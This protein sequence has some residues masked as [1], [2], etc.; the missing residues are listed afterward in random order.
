VL[1]A[2][3]AGLKIEMLDEKLTIR[4]VHGGNMTYD[5]ARAR[6]A[7]F[8]AFKRRIERRRSGA[9]PPAEAATD[10]PPPTGG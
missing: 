1:R 3:E 2:S 5:F 7:V 9:A 8:Q 4:R 10:A 6:S